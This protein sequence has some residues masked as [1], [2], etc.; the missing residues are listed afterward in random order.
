M[1]KGDISIS[2]FG[3]C[4]A[5][6]QFAGS[7]KGNSGG[8]SLFERGSNFAVCGLTIRD[9]ADLAICATFK[10]SSRG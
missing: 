5:Q 7:Q 8:V 6:W 4:G 3:L 10:G 1:D 2:E 9:T